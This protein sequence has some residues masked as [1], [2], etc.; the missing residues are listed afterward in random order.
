MWQFLQSIFFFSQFPSGRLTRARFRKTTLIPSD[1][2]V[3]EDEDFDDDR[4]PDYEP[5]P[6]NPDIPHDC[7]ESSAKKKSTKPIFEIEEENS[8][9]EEDNQNEE[10]NNENVEEHVEEQEE[11]QQDNAKGKGKAKGKKNGKGKKC[12]ADDTLQGRPTKWSRVDIDNPPLPEFVHDPPVFVLSPTEYFLQFY[13]E[14][15]IKYIVYQ[16]NLYAHQQDVNTTFNTDD[17]EIMTLIAIFLYMGIVYCIGF[18][19]GRSQRSQWTR[20]VWD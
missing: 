17:T 11:E 18:T 12:K 1:P 14:D 7:G 20:V 3:S 5:E 13:S 6:H 9:A 10:D 19:Y 15:L 4:D 8:D 16:T 2:T